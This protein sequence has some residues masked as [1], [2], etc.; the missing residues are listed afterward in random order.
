M[1]AKRGLAVFDGHRWRRLGTSDGLREQE[2]QTITPVDANSVWVSYWNLTGLTLVRITPAGAV[3]ADQLTRP[4]ALV[5]DTIYS[6]GLDRKSVLWLGTA[7][8]IKR[9]R[10]G[11][12]ERFGQSDG[13]PG[14]DAAANG[15][16]SDAS[17]DVWFG[18]ANGLAHFSARNDVDLPQPPTT[19]ITGLQDGDSRPLS[20]AIPSVP[21]KDRA[22]TFHVAALG[23]LSYEAGSA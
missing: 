18:M 13:L 23:F 14:E 3:V 16:W 8:G 17:G 19:V 1:S 7:M 20:A 11:V 9:F 12:T 15:F 21:W 10:N 5:A 6:A 2:I 4:D 22:L